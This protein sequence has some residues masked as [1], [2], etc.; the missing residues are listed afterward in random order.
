MI[1]SLSFIL[2]SFSVMIC[3]IFLILILSTFTLLRVKMSEGKLIFDRSKYKL[4]EKDE[5]IIIN[6]K[7]YWCGGKFVKGGIKDPFRGKWHYAINTGEEWVIKDIIEVNG[8]WELNIVRFNSNE[9]INIP[10]NQLN[11]N[12]HLKNRSLKH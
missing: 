4:P 11:Y 9:Y 2:G 10:Y 3:G 6:K 7:F 1:I 8:D 12:Q 5:Y